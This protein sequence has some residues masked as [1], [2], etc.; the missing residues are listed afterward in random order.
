MLRSQQVIVGGVQSG[1]GGAIFSLSSTLGINDCQFLANSAALGGAPLVRSD[2]SQICA[3]RTGAISVQRGTVSIQ[4]GTFTSNQAQQGGAV[5]LQKVVSL[6]SK[7]SN[8]SLPNTG[9]LLVGG[10][11]SFN[12]AN[13]EEFSLV[14]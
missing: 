10:S 2:H 8:P 7:S 5:Y 4:S 11:Y 12:L 14:F 9:A 13:G 1:S 3:T 6:S